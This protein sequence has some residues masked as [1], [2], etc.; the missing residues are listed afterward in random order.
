M[1]DVCLSCKNIFTVKNKG[2]RRKSIDT[3][4][5][6]KI[7]IVTF[8]TVL[9]STLSNPLTPSKK[10]I[11]NKC[12]SKCVKIHKL[13]DSSSAV[14]ELEFSLKRKHYVVSPIKPTVSD[15]KFRT[16]SKSPLPK[17]RILHS[18]PKITSAPEPPTKGFLEKAA[19]YLCESKYYT[20]FK[21]LYKKSKAARAAF[22]QFAK[23]VSRNEV[24]N[25]KKSG[26]FKKHVSLET[27][28]HFNWTDTKK[29]LEKA[30][31]FLSATIEGALTHRASESKLLV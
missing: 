10:Y 14:Q 5:T 4:L 26:T 16:P 15:F 3:V 2:Y 27:L 18:T 13:K 19:V 23:F 28:Q 20:C 21:L 12:V 1:G 7:P 31:P 30:V 25:V 8:R 24:S 9:D 6:T 17:R 11:C 29:N 22:A